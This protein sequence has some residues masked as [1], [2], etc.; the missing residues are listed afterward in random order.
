ME[1]CQRF[2]AHSLMSEQA[3][4]VR[5]WQA[6]SAKDGT[7]GRCF[8]VHVELYSEEEL[9]PEEAGS[10]FA[11]IFRHGSRMEGQ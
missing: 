1:D 3:Q 11:G 7:D 5:I 8:Y 10:W 6:G 2:A 9:E 4:R